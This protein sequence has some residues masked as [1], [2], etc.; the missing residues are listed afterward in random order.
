MTNQKHDFTRY[1]VARILGAR[2][3]QVAMD[4]PLL[5]KMSEEELK[6]IGYAALKIAEKEFDSG[7]L[8]ISVKRPF[9][10]KKEEKLETIKEERVDDKKII[11]KEKEIEEEITKKAGEMGFVA[12][13]EKEEE[14]SGELVS[15]EERE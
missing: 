7:V 13:D 8:P 5:L 1:E 9:P 14:D 6:E 15:E 3:L 10:T 12:R 2:A 11:E 4:A